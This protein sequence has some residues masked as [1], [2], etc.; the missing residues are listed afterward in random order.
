MRSTADPATSS[1]PE[2]STPR[3][4]C[5][6]TQSELDGRSR[7]HQSDGDRVQGDGEL[8]ST[9]DERICRT[10]PSTSAATACA[11]PKSWRSRS[12]SR[13]PT[14]GSR[15]GLTRSGWASRPCA[16]TSPNNCP[17]APR[18]LDVTAS[19][20]ISDAP[21]YSR[22]SRRQGA[23]R[24]RS[25]AERDFGQRRR[26]DLIP[27]LGGVLITHRRRRSGVTQPGHEFGQCGTGLRRQH[28]SGVP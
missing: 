25:V 17:I 22:R 15:P 20:R 3:R 9:L 13:S 5:T 12:R 10:P 11:G 23:S 24:N 2:P 4:R 19:L 6:P 26:D 21:P 1:S 8:M 14:N 7:G 18:V 16:R 27:A 28:C